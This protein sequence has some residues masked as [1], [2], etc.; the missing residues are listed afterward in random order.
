V[1][2][3]AD[4]LLARSEAWK[5]WRAYAAQHLWAA[6]PGLAPAQSKR[7]KTDDRQAA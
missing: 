2:P 4:Q 1:R 7:T 3:T 5:P 6:D